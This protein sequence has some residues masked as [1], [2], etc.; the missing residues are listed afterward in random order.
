MLKCSSY[1]AFGKRFLLQKEREIT[2]REYL[3]LRNNEWFQVRE[4][5]IIHLLSQDTEEHL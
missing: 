4:E 2:K 1:Y 5:E 3:S